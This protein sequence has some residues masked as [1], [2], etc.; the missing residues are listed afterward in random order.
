M[1]TNFNDKKI[2]ITTLNDG[3]I[4]PVK[5]VPGSSQSEI[6]GIIDESLKIKLN[7]PPIEGKANKECIKIL[8][9]ALKIAKS[10]IEITGGEKTKNKMILIKGNP[11]QILDKLK[12][13]IN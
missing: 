7:S 5:V 8:S 10:S 9:K 2:K 6:V 3:I 4:I 11:E 12:D 13:V 1:N